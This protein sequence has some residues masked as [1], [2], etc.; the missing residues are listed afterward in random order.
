MSE[1]D[2]IL[3]LVSQKEHRH[4]DRT[5]VGIIPVPN[6]Y[7]SLLSFLE[8]KEWYLPSIEKMNEYRK[9]EW[10]S[11]RVL[12]KKML[13]K[14]IEILYHPSGK[15]YL[16]DKSYHL[17]I[18]H[19]KGYAAIILSEEKEVAI[20]IEKISPRIEKIRSRFINNVEEVHLDKENTLIHL[21][22]HWSAKESLFKI[23]DEENIE[24]KSQL[25]INSFHPEINTWS[26]FTARE[27]RTERR[28]TYTVHY[29]V[30]PDYVLTYTLS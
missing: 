2:C 17:S 10:L 9:C 3:D 20:D 13:G 16:V 27:T 26:S 18:S 19:T 8:N 11:V 1:N 24:F 7:T 22:L 29:F 30:H 5:I 25:H 6:D 15:P 23:L 12:L 14:E 21:L 4:S 28:N